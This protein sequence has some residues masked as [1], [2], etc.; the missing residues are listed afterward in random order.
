MY[1]RKNTYCDVEC[2]TGEETA[3]CNAEKGAGDEETMIACDK[4]HKG[5]A[6]TPGDHASGG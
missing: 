4:A 5:H 3:L 2:D 1:A 6:E